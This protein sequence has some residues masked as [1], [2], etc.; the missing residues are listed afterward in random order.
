M[1][2]INQELV[3]INK[4]EMTSRKERISVVINAMAQDLRE[5]RDALVKIEN[6]GT[7]LAAWPDTGTGGGWEKY[8]F[9][10]DQHGDLFISLQND[11]N[12]KALI[13]GPFANTVTAS[14]I[15]NLTYTS[16]SQLG[17]KRFDKSRDI[18]I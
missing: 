17:A 12:D 15:V 13:L 10:F 9:D 3:P 4:S 1:Q 7:I 2:F 8:S 5:N 14:E 6:N 18:E 11:E 16:L